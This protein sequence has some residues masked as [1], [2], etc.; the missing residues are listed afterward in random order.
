M[1][2]IAN[3]TEGTAI[4]TIQ[5]NVEVNGVA[6]TRYVEP[7]LLLSD[8]LRQELGLTGTHVG[9]EHGVCGSCN[10]MVDGATARS[11]LVFAS[12]L[13]NVKIE[14]VESLGRVNALHPLQKA[15]WEKH[16]LQCGFCTPGMLMTAKE[17]LDRNPKPTREDIR[18]AIS[19]NL[20]R[21]TGYQTIIEAIYSAAQEMQ[22]VANG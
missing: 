12:Q 5:I 13:D 10:V 18:E 4:E 8:F 14:T 17:L 3:V 11:C 1:N 9:C 20:C 19:G 15:F 21:C 2:K 16:G 7:R 6:Y 22:G